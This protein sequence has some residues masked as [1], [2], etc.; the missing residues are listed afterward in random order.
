MK[1]RP[2]SS[3]QDVPATI[4]SLDLPCSRGSASLA[5]QKDHL[6]LIDNVFW[7]AK[8]ACP[9]LVEAAEPLKY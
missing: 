8:L 9:E 1:R 3:P 5:L 4:D 7:R 2:K 6:H